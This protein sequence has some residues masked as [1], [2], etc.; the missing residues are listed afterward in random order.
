MI[1]LRSHSLQF[2]VFAELGAF[3][4]GGEPMPMYPSLVYSLHMLSLVMSLL[5]VILILF[6]TYDGSPAGFVVLS[7]RHGGPVC[8]AFGVL[9]VKPRL[10][11]SDMSCGS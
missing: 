4:E 11:A 9:S 8:D 6:N 1:H 3:L 7:V 2:K 5:I 10:P